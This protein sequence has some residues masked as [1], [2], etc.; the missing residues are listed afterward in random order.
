MVIICP[1]KEQGLYSPNNKLRDCSYCDG[2][3]NVVHGGDREGY[4]YT[5]PNYPK[6]GG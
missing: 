4:A 1:K 5:C 2:Y 6:K 3:G